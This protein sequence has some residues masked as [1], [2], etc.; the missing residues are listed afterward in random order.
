M[1]PSEVWAGPNYGHTSGVFH[2]MGDWITWACRRCAY[3]HH[4]NPLDWESRP[5]IVKGQPPTF[6]ARLRERIGL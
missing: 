3:A 5:V 1:N 4:V 6:F 2:G